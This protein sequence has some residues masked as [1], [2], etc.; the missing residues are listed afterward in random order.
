[1]VAGIGDNRLSAQRLAELEV[2][3][4]PTGLV[5]AIQLRIHTARDHPGGETSGCA[6]HQLAI[7]DEHDLVRSA[8]IQVIPND[9]LEEGAPGLRAVEHAGIETPDLRKGHAIGK[10]RRRAAACKRRGKWMEQAP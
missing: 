6:R 7:E 9:T 8:D 1:E 10:A 2:L 3:L 5:G 4:E